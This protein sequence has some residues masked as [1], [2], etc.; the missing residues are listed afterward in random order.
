MKNRLIYTT[1]L[2]LLLTG[3]GLTQSISD[4][5]KSVTKSIFYKQVKT[6]S[7]DFVARAELNPDDDGTPLTTNLWVYQLKDRQTFDQAGYTALL[8]HASN[9]LKA[10]LLA[11]KDIW[12]RPGSNA[13]VTMPMDENT[14]Y[15]AI[16]VHVRTPDIQQDN[17][18]L[19]LKRDELDPDKARVIEVKKYSLT[20][21]PI[22]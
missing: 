17:W 1:L 21:Q 13:S 12:I 19:V 16:V 14:Q 11:E 22:K 7:L 18:R 9:I 8:S 10:D 2:A 6:L 5:T 20:L 3:C 4:G 15:V